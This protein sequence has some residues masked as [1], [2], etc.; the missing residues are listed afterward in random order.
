MLRLSQE[1]S[2]QSRELSEQMG[3]QIRHVKPYDYDIFCSLC[4]YA[5]SLIISHSL[6]MMQNTIS[7]F[8]INTTNT[9]PLT[10]NNAERPPRIQHDA[11]ITRLQRPHQILL[12]AR[13][14]RLGKRRHG[15]GCCE[16]CWR[17]M[18]TH[19]SFTIARSA[20]A[21]P[22]NISLG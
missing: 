9:I 20:C 7:V 17:S 22:A 14:R 8:H 15:P 10:I 19:W 12:A 5:N 16:V 1:F 11:P 3:A 2:E 4:D 13:C 6:S 18:T 21:L